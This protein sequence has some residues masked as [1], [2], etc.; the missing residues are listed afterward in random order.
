MSLKSIDIN[1]LIQAA[2]IIGTIIILIGLKM[3]W[4]K[5][6]D[7]AIAKDI[8][9][10]GLAVGKDFEALAVEVSAETK[11]TAPQ[12]LKEVREIHAEL[13]G[14]KKSVGKKIQRV[15]RKLLWRVLD[16]GL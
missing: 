1:A 11:F 6:S 7:F 15:G 2:E 8:V 3:K 9:K 10:S 14:D 4:W 13:K 5:Q 12:A 16:G